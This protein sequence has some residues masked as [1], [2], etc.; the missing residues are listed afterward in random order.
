MLTNKGLAVLALGGVTYLAGWMFGSEALYPVGV[1]LVIAV[2]AAAVW[3]RFLT[4]PSHLERDLAGRSHVDG[5]DVP[6]TLAVRVE[7][8]VPPAALMVRETVDELAQND[9]LLARRDGSFRGSYTIKGVRRG[10][11]GISPALVSVEDPFGFARHE[12]E[13]AVAGALIV[14]PR[15]V[16]LDGLFSDVGMRLTDGRRMLL[17]RQSGFDLHSVREHEP[18]ESLR[19]VHWPTSARRGE[20][21]VKELEDAPRDESLVVLD[22]NG[23]SLVGEGRDTTFELALRAAGSLVRAQ[24]ARGRRAGLLIND[25]TRSYQ[26]VHSMEGDWS[27]ALELLAFA[28]ADGHHPVEALLVDGAG[29]AAQAVEVTVV[30]WTLTPRLAER[31]LRRAGGRGGASLVYV[32]PTSFTGASLRTPGVAEARAQLRRLTGAGLPVATV[33]SGDDLA[34]EL[35]FAVPDARD[36]RQAGE[37]AAHA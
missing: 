2:A 19:R 31:L 13:Q 9:V 37:A 10:R 29:A 15:L 18:G 16:P 30:T 3:V 33:R 28:Q 4:H 34:K 26:A 7:G 32:D 25:A 23:S 22:A 17:R 12:T 8:L 1:G 24:A 5:D 6:V 21:M 11:Y 27:L 36:A 20:L 14:Y 35:S